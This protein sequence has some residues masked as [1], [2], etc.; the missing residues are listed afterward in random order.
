MPSSPI[1]RRGLRRGLR[2]GRA[3]NLR[4]STSDC[5]ASTLL[6]CTTLPSQALG[7]SAES[8]LMAGGGIGGGFSSVSES[9]RGSLL[10]GPSAGYPKGGVELF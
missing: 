10:T 8:E 6:G 9:L 7:S 4:R 2:D 3:I 5:R 1:R